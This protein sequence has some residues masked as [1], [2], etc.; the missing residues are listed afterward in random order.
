M[1]EMRPVRLAMKEITLTINGKQ[2][3][4]KEGDTV[5]QVCQSNGIDVPTLC[6]LDGLSDVGACRICVVEVERERRPVPACT[7]PASNGMVV[8]T[9]TPALENYRRLIL[10]LIFTEHNHFCMFCG[11]SGD[12]E[13]QKL[14]YRY[15]MDHVRY[16]YSFASLPVDS[17]SDYMVI[18]HNRCIL[19]GRCIRACSEVVGVHTLDFGKRGWRTMV[20]ADIGQPLGKSSCIACGTCVQAC[21]TGTIL[22]KRGLYKGRT[23]E[24]QQV[25]TICPLCGVGCEL[26]VLVKD[27]NLVKT[28]APNLKSP[29][30]TLCQKGRFGLLYDERLRVTSPLIR[31]KQGKLKE[32]TLDKAIETAA[33]KLGELKGKI[34]GIIS[35]RYPRETLLL[36]NKFVREVM[37]SDK[38]DTLDGRDYRLIAEGIKQFGDKGK[39]LDIE[40]SI[41][42]ILEADCILVVG[43]D[44][45]KTHPIVGSLIAR[46]VSHRKA[47]LLVVDSVKDGLPLWSDLW[48]QPKAGSEEA[49]LSGLTKIIID[50]GL[51]KRE[52]ATKHIQSPGHSN[53]KDVSKATGI[54]IGNLESA[55]TMYGEAK[56]GIIIYGEGLLERNDP[57]LVTHL[58]SLA[59]LTGNWSGDRL[60]IVSLKGANSRGAWE[61]GL[62]AKDTTHDKPKGVYLLLADES[63][64]EKLLN[65]LKG[66]NFLV[67]Q[68]SYHSPVTSIADVVLPSPIWA[69][70]EGG[71][72]TSMDG[73]ISGS[74][75]V[76]QL[77]DGLLQDQEILVKLSK[78]LGLNVGAR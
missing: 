26:N 22:S 68:A 28:E 11:Q 61:L 15:Q 31:D 42:E 54:D 14:G 18:D 33:T 58:L 41:D 75:Q 51:V 71:K 13:L 50:K 32:D 5:L 67:V 72:Y 45:M 35:T 20:C 34:D 7:H 3:T 49:L 64:D 39:G 48:L 23:S 78:K 6:H 73:R 21:P 60:R 57:K 25:R 52:K 47:K 66:I 19:C 62:A 56:R 1:S 38:L 69:E 12:C 36:F 4:G 27:N 77:K 29:R 9:N 55:A 24:C 16:P 70:R 8:K 37:G 46:A 10:E 30:G 74:Q 63:E 44:P 53:P 65:W 2:V 43:A 17:S 76:L 59:D 40:C